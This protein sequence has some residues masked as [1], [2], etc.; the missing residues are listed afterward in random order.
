MASASSYSN[1]SRKQNAAAA[2]TCNKDEVR[3]RAFERE[4]FPNYMQPIRERYLREYLEKNLGLLNEANMKRIRYMCTIMTL[5]PTHYQVSM[6]EAM[7]F[8]GLSEEILRAALHDMRRAVPLWQS[9][10]VQESSAYLVTIDDHVKNQSSEVRE[11]VI[12]L[13]VESI[14]KFHRLPLTVLTK[15]VYDMFRKKNGLEAKFAPPLSRTQDATMQI[16][17]I[18]QYNFAFSLIVKHYA[19]NLKRERID[20]SVRP[21]WCSINPGVT[22]GTKKPEPQLLKDGKN[23]IREYALK[24]NSSVT[25]E[26]LANDLFRYISAVRSFISKDRQ[27]ANLPSIYLACLYL[28]EKSHST[29]ITCDDVSMIT[30]ERVKLLLT[31]IEEFERL[32]IKLRFFKSVSCDNPEAIRDL[33]ERLRFNE[34]QIVATQHLSAK[35]TQKYKSHY[36]VTR[37]SAVIYIKGL[38]YGRSEKNMMRIVPLLTLARKNSFTE[39]LKVVY[40]DIPDLKPTHS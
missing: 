24:L 29:D 1:T 33:G 17:E 3:K 21:N 11:F 39:F 16:H 13:N 9:I 20:F 2:V 35:L 34:E 30:G 22:P 19:Q 4:I 6:R 10:F 15:V 40:R 27:Y 5:H 7:H 28:A 37:A 38:E 8:T 14:I 25:T 23:S 36:F 31:G 26:E 18:D 12:S 32:F